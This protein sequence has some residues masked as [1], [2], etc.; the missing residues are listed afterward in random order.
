MEM[1]RE[2]PATRTS[3]EVIME[4]QTGA[5]FVVFQYCVSLLVVTFKSSSDV[6]LIK[7]GES[8][9]RKGM[10]YTLL[11]LLLGW[12]GIPWGPVYALESIVINLQGGRD[13]TEK[14]VG[15]LLPSASAQERSTLERLVPQAA[16]A[17]PGVTMEEFSTAISAAEPFPTA[18]PEPGVR[19]RQVL[20]L[21]ALVAVGLGVL[22]LAI[23]G[24]GEWGQR[25]D[26]LKAGVWGLPAQATATWEARLAR[27]APTVAPGYVFY[28]NE[29]LCFSVHHPEGWLVEV[30]DL[31]ELETGDLA[32]GGVAFLTP[33]QTP[34]EMLVLWVQVFW[35]TR[36]SPLATPT[37]QEYF[38]VLENFAGGQQLHPLEDP[39]LLDLDG[40]RAAQAA[41]TF[42]DSND[43]PTLAHHSTMLYAEERT[44]FIVG[45]AVSENNEELSSVY[46]HF[47]ASFRVLP[48]P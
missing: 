30:G 15:A 4:L 18:R 16:A 14:V 41:Y 44:F 20:V 9:V 12:W 29:D 23:A 17:R 7:P 38:Y 42:T 3:A 21:A 45:T 34:E 43:S 8:A 13:V 10:G 27:P 40:F 26:S 46:D 5:R 24:L 28:S 35:A 6:H 48:A 1:S 39:H 32:S 19:R 37:D 36:G 25:T 2:E 47:L 11:S 33:T 22:A 31:E